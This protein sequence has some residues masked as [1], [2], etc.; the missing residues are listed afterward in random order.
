MTR[1]RRVALVAAG[2]DALGDAYSAWASGIVDARERALAAFS[3]RLAPGARVLDLGCGAGEPSTTALAARFAVTG[4]DISAAQI[5]AARRLVPRA[6]F[7]H[8]DMARV[9]FPPG[10]FDGIT[11]L[12]SINHV[13]REEHAG[14]FGRIAR[15]LAPGGLFLGVLGSADSPGWVGEWLGQPMFFSSHD[16]ATYRRLLANAGFALLM[17]DILETVEP[18]GPVEFLWVIAQRVI[19]SAAG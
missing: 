2:Y 4:V 14:L 8:A 19:P 18:E 15:W 7:V 10:S 9:D 13:P 11:A 1:D 5:D 3:D 6:T 17:D 12:Y 16:A